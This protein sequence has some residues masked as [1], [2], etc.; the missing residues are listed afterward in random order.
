MIKFGLSDC[1]DKLVPVKYSILRCQNFFSTIYSKYAV[2][3][4]FF[5]WHT[6]THTWIRHT[7]THAYMYSETR[8][9]KPWNIFVAFFFLFSLSQN[10]FPRSI[11]A[12]AHLITRMPW[13]C[14]PVKIYIYISLHLPLHITHDS[15]SGCCRSDIHTFVFAFIFFLFFF[16]C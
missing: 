14:K 15:R 6:K 3:F 11:I 16:S 12:A 2:F 10:Y 8:A 7:R 4:L 9:R 5:P 1:F 13:Y